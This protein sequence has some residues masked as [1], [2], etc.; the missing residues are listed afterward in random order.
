MYIFTF[1]LDV[2]LGH[3]WNQEECN[4]TQ[5]MP[6]YTRQFWNSCSTWDRHCA[7]PQKD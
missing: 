6:P 5:S 7:Q 1:W 3:W 2:Q 4:L